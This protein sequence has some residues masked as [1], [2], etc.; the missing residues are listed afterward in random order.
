MQQQIIEQCNDSD[1]KQVVCD[2]CGITYDGE[3]PRWAEGD[4]ECPEC[5]HVQY[6]Y[7]Q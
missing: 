5:D 4:E 2:S 7:K 1:T 3:L 6:E